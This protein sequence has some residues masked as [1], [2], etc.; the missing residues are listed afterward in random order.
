M[1][2]I[3]AFF[4]IA[5]LVIAAIDMMS[6]CASTNGIGKATSTSEQVARNKAEMSAMAD[7]SRTHKVTIA[8]NSKMETTDVDGNATTVYKDEITLASSATLT[9]VKPKTRVEKRGKNVTATTK[10]NAKVVEE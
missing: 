7:V 6:S 1:K 4:L 5:A 10:I 2:K 8:E 9:E 3:F